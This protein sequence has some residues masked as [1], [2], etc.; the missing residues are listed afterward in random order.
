MELQINKR[1]RI[2]VP[3]DHMRRMLGWMV[4]D[5]VVVLAAYTFA[6]F[7]RAIPSPLYFFQNFWFIVLATVIISVMLVSFGVYRRIWS[8]T[9]GHDATIILSAFVGA[10]PLIAL[11]DV[12][13]VAR[14]I[15]LSVTL[16]G[17]FVAMSSIVALRYRSRLVTG[18][19]WRWKAIWGEEFPAVDTRVLIIGAGEDGQALAWRLK[20]RFPKEDA[21]K[22]VGFVDDDPEKL[23]MYVEGCKI[24]GSRND[25]PRIADSNN[26]DVIVVAIHNIQ[27]QAFREI[28]EICESTNARIKIAPDMRAFMSAK[29]STTLLRDI[30]AEDL[31]GRGPV[32]RHEAVNLNLVTNKVIL[33]TGAAGSIGSELS[34][35]LCRYN[36]KNVIILD[37]NES[38]LHELQIELN[39]KFP[40]TWIEPAL[41]DITNRD[42][43]RTVFA[44]YRPQIVFH[45]AAYK[46]VPMM[47][48]YP[49]EALRV[50][51]GG[52]RNLTEFA[53]EFGVERFVLISTDKAVKPSSVMGAS[54][55]A[56]ELLLRSLS[57]QAGNKTLFTSVRFGNVFGSRGSVVPTFN[58]QIENGG[59]VT[60][61]DPEMSRYFMSIAEAV[62]LV[63]HAACMTRGGDSFL[64][65]MGEEV[66]IM[67][68]AERMIRLRG[69]RP[70]VDIEIK[71]TGM[72]P[73]EKLHEELHSETEIL[74]D[75]IHPNI[76][77]LR[78]KFEEF[79]AN[80]YLDRM[81]DVLSRG[82]GATTD[83][84]YDLIEEKPV[85]SIAE[86][87]PILEMVL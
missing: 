18:A 8:M 63:I 29:H 37:N 85:T 46:H 54:K 47:E 1:T 60:I 42:M 48:R 62:N 79:D 7:A 12:A 66:R 35:Q 22:V 77:Q 11:L 39:A 52:T 33:V 28:L 65:K 49:G 71:V 6:F 67:D 84:L 15:P 24:L 21:Y 27:G 43:M 72:R 4:I 83:D 70:G 51:L 44:T 82:L 58:N 25:I 55:R 13:I 16:I 45:A 64:L 30:K 38:G 69:M 31:I 26:I 86:E 57:E 73:G 9:S 78:S 2:P 59:P 75:T 68:L 74:L 10:T 80:N 76:V 19:V 5:A 50:N 3:A 56:C 81:S 40:D 23:R 34:R 36:A 87:T 20:H 61:T 14:P 17:N 41:V 32:T 53:R